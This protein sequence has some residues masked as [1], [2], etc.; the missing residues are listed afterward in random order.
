MD[1]DREV[2]IRTAADPCVGRRQEGKKGQNLWKSEA[3]FRNVA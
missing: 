3:G 1:A 2:W